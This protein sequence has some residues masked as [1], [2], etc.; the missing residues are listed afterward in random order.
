MFYNFHEKFLLVEVHWEKGS[1]ITWNLYCKCDSP[2][3]FTASQ[4]KSSRFEARF[5]VDIPDN[6]D[7][8]ITF[9]PGKDVRDKLFREV[10]IECESDSRTKHLDK[11]CTV[12]Y[13][14]SSDWHL[15]FKI[16]RYNT[17]KYLPFVTMMHFPFGSKR[18][19][20]SRTLIGEHIFS[21]YRA[22]V[23]F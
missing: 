11:S 13:S 23:S 18:R 10:V 3:G 16:F 14:C 5:G 1:P 15:I 6:V 20:E 9:K 22:R 12:K 17:V 4:L 21:Y 8:V 2:S 7:P 19:G